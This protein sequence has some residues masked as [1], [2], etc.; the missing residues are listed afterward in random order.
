MVKVHEQTRLKTQF[1]ILHNVHLKVKSLFYF[2]LKINQ[3]CQRTVESNLFQILQF[4]FLNHAALSGA[5]SFLVN[6]FERLM[7]N[8]SLTFT[9]ELVQRD[10]AVS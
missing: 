1:A 6:G 7:L 4:C 9:V 8:A 2:L 10:F 3:I 5:V